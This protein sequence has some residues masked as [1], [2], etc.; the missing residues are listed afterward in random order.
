MTRF[1]LSLKRVYQMTNSDKCKVS[2]QHMIDKWPRSH[3][4]RPLTVRCVV[5]FFAALLQYE[6][7]LITIWYIEVKQIL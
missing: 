7:G 5:V 1:C 3:R 2:R 4:L 6:G